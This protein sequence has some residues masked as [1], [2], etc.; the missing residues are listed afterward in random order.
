MNI[1]PL[2]VKDLQYE[3]NKKYLKCHEIYDPM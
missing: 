2:T 1:N 3:V